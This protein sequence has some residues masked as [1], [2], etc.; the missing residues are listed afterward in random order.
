VE[1]GPPPCALRFRAPCA[2]EPPPEQTVLQ[3]A[4]PFLL[5]EQLSL[6]LSGVEVQSCPQE[7]RSVYDS[8]R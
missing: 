2:A 4:K 3:V 8:M 6:Q 7:T 5:L 1:K